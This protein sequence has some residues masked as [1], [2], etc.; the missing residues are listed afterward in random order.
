MSRLVYYK[1]E[2]EKL[3]GELYE[4]YEFLKNDIE[5]SELVRKECQTRGIEFMTYEELNEYVKKNDI[6]VD[7]DENV[8]WLFSFVMEDNAVHDTR[9]F[10]YIGGTEESPA[11]GGISV[12]F[13]VDLKT[14]S[15]VDLFE[16]ILA[17]HKYTECYVQ[18]DVRHSKY[19]YHN[20]EMWFVCGAYCVLIGMV[21][22][23]STCA[24]HHVSYT[25]DEYASMV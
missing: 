21:D 1:P 20:L 3:I 23:D 4:Y 7:N 11:S 9:K 15:I 14:I 24:G 13:D 17:N 6:D 12:K 25:I 10:Y 2:R 8:K 22:D 18:K 19:P 5:R 16:N